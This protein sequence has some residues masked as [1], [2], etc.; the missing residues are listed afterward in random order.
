[1]TVTLPEGA[2]AGIVCSNRHFIRLQG[3]ATWSLSERTCAAGKELTPSTYAVLAPQ[4]G[5]FKVVRGLLV[6]EREMRGDADPLAP[7]I[8]V[9]GNTMLRVPRPAVVWTRVPSA[10]EYLVEWNGRGDGTS[11]TRLHAADLSCAAAADGLDACSLP[12]PAEQ[13]GLPP[14]SIFFLTVAARQELGEPWHSSAEVKVQTLDLA[15][16]YTLE[17]H[18]RDLKSLGLEEAQREAARAGL[19]AEAG[20][21][22]DAA[23]AYR[24]ALALAPT[25]E[26][27]ITLADI[28]L[29]I[30][31]LPSAERLY[32]QA[33]RESDAACQAAATFGLGRVSYSRRRFREAATQFNR[34]RGLYADLKL[35][36][37]EAAARE[38][39]AE[40]A[41]RIPE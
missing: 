28:D 13:P 6:L 25:P 19:F 33:L 30:G 11:S 39:A 3:P 29:T 22:S 8:L 16:A 14:G 27:R 18:L 32:L 26:L 36:D 15:A 10:A 23:E 9:P 24:R 4:A 7:D 34:A 41:K 38:A 35:R 12:W 2:A 20:L 40:A 1:V 5:R 31:L 21:Y 17:S 37:E